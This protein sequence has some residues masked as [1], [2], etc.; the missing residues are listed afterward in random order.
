GNGGGNSTSGNAAA[1]AS[2]GTAGDS[3]LSKKAQATVTPQRQWMGFTV[4]WQFVQD[5][6]H[7]TS[8]PASGGGGKSHEGVD[9]GLVDLAVQL[10]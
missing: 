9:E 2:S 4:L 10:L 5:P 3:G 1:A 8:E 7:A 6:V